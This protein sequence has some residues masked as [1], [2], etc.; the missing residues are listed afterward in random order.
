MVV[1]KKE[2]KRKNM[3]VDGISIEFFIPNLSIKATTKT[4]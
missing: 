4:R 3:E 1:L 2:E